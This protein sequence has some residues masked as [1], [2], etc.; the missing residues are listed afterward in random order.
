MNNQPTN[1]YKKLKI[2]DGSN[3]ARSLC[4]RMGRTAGRPIGRPE[5]PSAARPRT[6]RRPFHARDERSKEQEKREKSLLGGGGG[7][8]K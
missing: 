3:L 5:H 1:H 4:E 2:G 7:E 6:S 8:K